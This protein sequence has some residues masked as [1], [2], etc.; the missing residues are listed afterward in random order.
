MSGVICPHCGQNHR[1]G[2]KFCPTT[3]LR[4]PSTPLAGEQ[5]SAP[6]EI[7]SSSGPVAGARD[8][9]IGISGVSGGA[10][11]MD[12]PPGLAGMTGRLPPN[13]FL[14]NRYL[15]LRKIGQGGMA[16]VYQAAD[17]TPASSTGAPVLFTG[18]QSGALWAIKEMSDAALSSTDREY[19]VQS[20]LQEGNLLRSLSHPNLPK[21]IDVFTEG[22][23]HYLVME[24]I[25]GQTMQAAL[26][27][28]TQPFTQAEVLPWAL[29]LCDVFIYLHSQNPKIIFRDLKPSNIMITPQAQ[30]KLIDFGIVRFFKPGKSRDTLALGTP[31]YAAQEAIGGQTDERSDLYSLCVTLH[32]LLTLNDP[33]KTMFHIPPTCQLNPSI[34][35]ELGHIL[36]RGL[37][38]QRELRWA[39]V[40]EM[41]AE[42]VRLTQSMGAAGHVAPTMASGTPV[43]AMVAP[44]LGR[45]SAAAAQMPPNQA[46]PPAGPVRTVAA[47][48]NVTPPYPM[49]SPPHSGQPGSQGTYP[50]SSP[51]GQPVQTQA[52]PY[53]PGIRPGGTPPYASTMKASL[54]TSRP[55]T[56]LLMV[57]TQLTG[58]QLAI[59]ATGFVILLV[60]ATLV[61]APFLDDLPIDWNQVPIIAIF[62]AL[63]Y[64]AYPRRG[65]AFVS[66]A[67]LSAILVATLWLR[68]GNQGYSW[69]LLG[70]GTLLSGIFVEVWV[71]FLPRV[72]GDRG[73]DAWI[74][75]AAWLAGMA[76]LGTIIFFGLVTNW[77]TGLYPAQW[78]MS[79]VL[80][81]IGWF[82][83]DILKQYLLYRKTGLRRM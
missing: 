16:A 68:L 24:Y 3:G 67:V 28:R 9:G 33:A 57:A 42:L 21:V 40:G 26:E 73:D 30:I 43:G 80:G 65:T 61:L 76:T 32:Q 54:G 38:N 37:Q 31:G 12:T 29:Q 27:Q 18:A 15:I 55:T 77:V 48:S 82:L 4:F 25:P 13:S 52:A 71:S 36:D 72:K 63:G 66:H 19:A 1:D 81:V 22:G 47:P 35:Q 51:Y 74:R 14:R 20:F 17:T 45:A 58:R 83:G 69:A 46:F 23:K 75:E 62:G 50:G 41:R 53:G 39:S 34:S 5:A 2:A 49:P 10:S 7:A 6:G 56:R 64:S 70:L 11:R 44:G 79:A 78:I 59:L 8:S 60:V